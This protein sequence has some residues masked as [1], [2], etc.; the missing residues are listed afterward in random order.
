MQ[1]SRI[2]GVLMLANNNSTCR[3][4]P[5]FHSKLWLVFALLLGFASGSGVS[6]DDYLV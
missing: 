2:V 6:V 1:A 4:L 5:Q 3:W